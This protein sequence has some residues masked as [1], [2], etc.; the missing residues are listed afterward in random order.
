MP[1]EKGHCDDPHGGTGRRLRES[2]P[3]DVA[4]QVDHKEEV[5]A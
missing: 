5:F 4:G 1:L 3:L 2:W